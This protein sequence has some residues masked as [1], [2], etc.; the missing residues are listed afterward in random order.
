MTQERRH[1]GARAALALCAL[2]ALGAVGCTQVESAATKAWQQRNFFNSTPRPFFVGGETITLSED[3]RLM[4]RYGAF[5]RESYRSGAP[6]P[7]SPE[8][9]RLEQ[10]IQNRRLVTSL[11]E[12]RDIQRGV[13]RVGMSRAQLLASMGDLSLIDVLIE[14]GD[15][16]ETFRRAPGLFRLGG[17]TMLVCNGVVIGWQA[18]GLVAPDARSA[19][20][21]SGRVKWMTNFPDG[22]WSD[23]ATRDQRMGPRGPY[24]GPI[25]MRDSGGG[26]AHRFMYELNRQRTPTQAWSAIQDFGTAARRRAAAAQSLC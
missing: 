17:D 20:F 5:L 25:S 2:I 26:L 16:V 24:D 19:T 14:Y 15:T 3:D 11:E 23:R 21:G 4:M 7:D 13:L 22:Y 1:L 6:T 12:V 18:Y 10:E 9:L 8:F